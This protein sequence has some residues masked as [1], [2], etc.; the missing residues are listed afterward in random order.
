MERLVQTTRTRTVCIS[1]TVPLVSP[2]TTVNTTLTSV[3]AT[4]VTTEQH[5]TTWSMATTAPVVMVTQV[6]FDM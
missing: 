1:A 4:P 5:A 3:P 2:A 6:S